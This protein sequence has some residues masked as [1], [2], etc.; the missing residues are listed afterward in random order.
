MSSKT[1][2]QFANVNPNV[3][4]STVIIIAIFLAIVIIAP[5]SFE[6]LTQQLKQWITDSFSW[7]YVLSVAVFL[8]LL[9]Y[10]ACSDSGKIKL[11]PDHSQPEY[12]NGSWFAML[13]TAGMGI[14]LMFFG[15]AE[16]VMHYVSPPSGDPESVA[17]AQQALRITFFHWGLHAWAIY[18]LVGLA[19][20]YFAYRHNLPLKTRSALYPIIG[21]RI[22]GPLG[23]SI[24]TFATI[25]TVFGVATSLGFGV[26]QINSGLHY[27]FGIEQ[28][29]NIQV[30]LII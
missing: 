19:L 17:S 10:I 24:D 23:D 27:L 7:F 28:S 8:I 18:A 4:F 20:A 22:Y 3:F 11:G 14:G 21:E 26:T 9:I 1:P 6:F 30:G 5:S 2:S 13:F 15:V 25:G 29:T 12:K 16:P